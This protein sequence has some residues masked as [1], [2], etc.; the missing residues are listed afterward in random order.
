MRNTFT[1]QLEPTN[2]ELSGFVY[3]APD[4]AL[5]ELVSQV[6]ISTR[7]V[8]SEPLCTLSYKVSNPSDEVKIEVLGRFRLDEDFT[9]LVSFVVGGSEPDADNQGIVSNILTCPEMKVRVEVTTDA[10]VTLG[11][12]HITE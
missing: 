5:G 2:G 8:G 6:F 12:F 11:Y 3:T 7:D 10:A 1:A 4:D 9:P